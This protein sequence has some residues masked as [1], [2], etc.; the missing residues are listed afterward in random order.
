MKKWRND[1]EEREHLPT[2]PG[3][4]VGEDKNGWMEGCRRDDGE[5]LNGST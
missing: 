4:Q 1:A 5:C 2:L 3:I